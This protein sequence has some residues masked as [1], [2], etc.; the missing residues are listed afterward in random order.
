MDKEIRR[1]SVGLG[2]VNVDEIGN[3]KLV[4]IEELEVE[5]RGDYL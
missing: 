1:V 2:T 4:S 3:Y 5:R